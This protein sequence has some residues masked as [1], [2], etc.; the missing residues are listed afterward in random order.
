[1]MQAWC[2]AD[3]C[4]VKTYLQCQHKTSATLCSVITTVVQV[5]CDILTI[6]MEIYLLIWWF[7]AHTL[8]WNTFKNA[9]ASDMMRLYH[10]VDFTLRELKHCNLLQ[11]I[12]LLK[13]LFE[14]NLHELWWCFGHKN[15][16]LQIDFRSTM[17][18]S[19]NYWTCAIWCKID[20]NIIG[21]TSNVQY[22]Y[23]PFLWWK[24]LITL[25][26]K[27]WFHFDLRMR[28]VSQA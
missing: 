16:S 14:H 7:C 18:L 4:N 19:S 8:S 9:M 5:K 11:I 27:N 26:G 28:R 24:A 6:L 12:Q 20:S 17:I 3:V 21:I 13:L 22:F 15:S 2:H 25:G 10:L 1:M 23:I